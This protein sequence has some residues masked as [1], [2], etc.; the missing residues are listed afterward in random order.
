MNGWMGHWRSSDAKWKFVVH[1]HPPYSSDENDY[2][3]LEGRGTRGDL[4]ARKLTTLYDRYG[5]DLVLN[6]HIHS[7]ERTWPISGGRVVDDGGVVYTI[8]G[9]GGVDWRR[10][11][12]R[13]LH[14]TTPFEEAI[15]TAW[16]VSTAIRW[17]SSP[18]IWTIGSLITYAADKRRGAVVP[19][20]LE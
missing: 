7:Y 6:G 5:V 3:D 19:N 18:M 2:G 14:S 17:S 10:P 9:G 4:R 15:T 12:H 11:D 13:G 1:H 8:T 20:E 16:F